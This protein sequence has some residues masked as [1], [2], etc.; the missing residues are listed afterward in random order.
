MHWE[1]SSSVC[2][3]IKARD[4]CTIEAT[5]IVRRSP[6]AQ[7]RTAEH[8]EA[9]GES[10]RRETGSEPSGRFRAGMSRHPFRTQCFIPSVGGISK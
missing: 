1:R 3:K 4:G 6:D 9:A 7:A 5:Q 10:M 8:I 2:G